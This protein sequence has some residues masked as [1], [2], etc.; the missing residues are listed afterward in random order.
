MKTPAAYSVRASS[1]LPECD[2]LKTTIGA[3][4]AASSSRIAR[5]GCVGEITA[6][7]LRPPVRRGNGAAPDPI[8]RP[9]VFAEFDRICAAR[10]A[11]GCVLEIGAAARDD[12]LLCLPALAGAC[13]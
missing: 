3:G 5:S 8:V 1:R 11:G 6:R 2:L 10:R 12:T 7:C 9:E 4:R 13:E